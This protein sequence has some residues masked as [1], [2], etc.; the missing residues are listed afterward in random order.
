MKRSYNLY[1]I[2]DGCEEA[3]GNLFVSFD[4]S[5]HRQKAI[6]DRLRQYPTIGQ[7]VCRLEQGQFALWESLQWQAQGGGGGGGGRAACR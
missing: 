5:V 3:L 4:S 1:V 2:L 7:R 6:P